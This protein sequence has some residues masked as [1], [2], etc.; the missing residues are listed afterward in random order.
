[1]TDLLNQMVE[2][3]RAFGLPG[4]LGA[5]GIL[6]IVFIARKSGLIVSGDQAR[7]ANIVVAAILAALSGGPAAE[8]ALMT[9][10]TSV[11]ASVIYELLKM[12]QTKAVP[13][14]TAV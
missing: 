9:V 8:T 10:L 5:L 2:A 12:I 4:L 3:L 7:I 1:M 11:L 13:P 6:A 14:R